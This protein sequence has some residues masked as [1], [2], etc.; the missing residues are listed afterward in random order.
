MR[1]NNF[2]LEELELIRDNLHRKDCPDINHKLL[3]LNQK[4]DGL[5][6][7]YCDHDWQNTY[8]E[9]EIWRCTKCG[10]TD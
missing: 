6:E 9:Q 7:N 2:T 10:N 5:I 8:S 3:Q 1:D 4:L